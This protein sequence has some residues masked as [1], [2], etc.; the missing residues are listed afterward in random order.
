LVDL[1]LADPAMRGSPGLI[2]SSDVAALMA[3]PAD[4]SDSTDTEL[5]GIRFRHDASLPARAQH[6]LPPLYETWAGDRI[7]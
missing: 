2:P 3:L 6:S 4:Q 1:I 5:C 7:N